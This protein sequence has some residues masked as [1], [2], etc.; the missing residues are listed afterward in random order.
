M[1]DNKQS[2]HPLVT[3][4]AGM[5]LSC[6]DPAAVLA[7][8]QEAAGWQL[9]ET[10]PIDAELERSWGVAPG[11]AGDDYWVLTAPGVDRGRLRVVMGPT[12]VRSRPVATRWAGIEVLV[13]RDIDDLFQRLVAHDCFTV[14]QEPFDMDWSEFDSNVHRAFI[15]YGPGGTHMAFT[16]AITKPKGREFP[17]A[18]SAVGHIFDV[19]LITGDYAASAS[20]YRQALGMIPF[21]E[22]RFTSGP[23]HE[24]W[25]ISEGEEVVL[26]ILKGDAPGTGLGGIEMQAYAGHCIDPEPAMA[27]RFDGGT[28]LASYSSADLDAAFAV[29]SA[30]DRATV[31]SSPTVLAC[32]PYHG[33]RAFS[34]L[35]PTGER[36]EIFGA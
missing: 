2:D 19:P 33:Q 28:C 24:L 26:D 13:M 7:L 32:W 23:W 34:F 17:K 20:F 25:G 11:S 35:G 36:V 5:T 16:M 30:S 14:M 29:V 9:L 4:L 10:G 3:A 21:L 22:S 27:D 12:R 8:F 15:G 18:D 6:P 1:T 31:L